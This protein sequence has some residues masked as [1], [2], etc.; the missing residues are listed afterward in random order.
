MLTLEAINLLQN[1]AVSREV[2]FPRGSFKHFTIQR[3]IKI[4]VEK[5]AFPHLRLSQQ[6]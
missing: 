3:V 6:I 2:A 4:H 5:V 1:D